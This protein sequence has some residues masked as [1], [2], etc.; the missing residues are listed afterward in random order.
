MPGEVLM[1]FRRTAYL[2]RRTPMGNDTQL[3][4]D[5]H[6]MTGLGTTAAIE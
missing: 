1:I 6:D 5:P 3:C 4:A 2:A